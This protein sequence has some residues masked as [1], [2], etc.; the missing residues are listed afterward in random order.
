MPPFYLCMAMVRINIYNGSSD[1]A[2]KEAVRHFKEK[3]SKE[4]IPT[5]AAFVK[6]MCSIRVYGSC[7]VLAVPETC[8]GQRKML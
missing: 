2:K 7:N 1:G 6:E 3:E 5:N 8:I 4:Y